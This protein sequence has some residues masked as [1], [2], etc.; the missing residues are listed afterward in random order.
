[1]PPGISDATVPNPIFNLSP[2][3][4]VDEGNNWINIS[5]GPLA[6]T[7]PVTN[8]TLGNY[9]PSSDSPA[10]NYIPSTANLNYHNAPSLDFYGT[11]RKT[12]NAVDAGAVEY[13]GV[14]RAVGSV[15]GGPLVFGNVADTTNSAAQTLTLHN[16]GTADLTGITVTVTAP[17]SRA[18]GSCGA[19]LTAAAATCTIT[20]VFSPTTPGATTG[21]ATITANE[22]VLGSPVALSGAG[23][24][25]IER[26]TLT[27]GTWTVSQVRN[28]PGT[29]LGILA[30][31]LDPSQAFTLTNTGN[32]PLT[33]ITQGAL[34]G[35]NA[36]EFIINYLLSTCGPA[37][38]GQLAAKTTLAPG[39]T[40]VIRVQFKPLTAQPTGV[41][42]A[43]ISVSDL[44]G[45]Q[46]ATVT[47]TAQ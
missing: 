45:T 35:T 11:P 13:V 34:A 7:G 23:V 29:G 2:S 16:T 31:N 14:P 6:M 36:S 41:K 22:S 27:P 1:V 25:A 10:I 12:N 40:C 8:T 21:T 26:A 30:C 32:A 39:A 3:A 33:G 5:W 4:T 19:T 20:V 43:T 44:V 24:A 42:N 28:C 38:N 15:T 9:G 37:A 47:G 18:G 46:I 17:Y